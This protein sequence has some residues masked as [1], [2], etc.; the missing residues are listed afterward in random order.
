VSSGGPDLFVVCK[1]CHSEVSPY[2]TECPYCGAR[3]RKRAPKLDKEGRIAERPRRRAR[4][5]KRSGPTLGR[6]RAGEMPGIRGEVR[7]WLS[8][9]AVAASLV[10]LVLYRAGLYH[11]ADIA[12]I[13]KLGSEPWRILTAPFAY[14]NTGYAFIALGAIGLFGTLLER[15][16]GF[17][18]VAL[19]LV[20]GGAGGMALAATV[21]A[22][23]LAIGGNG[24]A[25]ALIVAWALPD[26][27]GRRR[28][29]PVEGDLLGA[30]VFAVV[31]AVIPAFVPEADWLA[32]LGGLVVGL[33][34]GMPLAA[35]GRRG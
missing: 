2:I 3:L 26:V 25:L 22:F 35:L 11:V 8:F 20:A 33:V 29:E 13:G 28:G 17:I 10:L 16:H 32:G 7:P 18:V 4:A 24:A 30:A 14:T 23:P 1:N 19:L 9:T 27:L 5:R 6:L 12:V 21:E 34:V 31:V 15:R